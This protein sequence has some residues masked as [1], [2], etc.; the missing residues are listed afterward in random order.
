MN[1]SVVYPPGAARPLGLLTSHNNDIE[2]F[3][4]D[5]AIP[6]L[7]V[8]LL[9]KYLPRNIR[10]NNVHVL[11]SKSNVVQACKI[12]QEIDGRRKLYI[13]DG[14]MELLTGSPKPRLRHLY[15]L[16]GYCVENYLLDEGALV[17]AVT[18]VNTRIDEGSARQQINFFGWLERNQ[19]CLKGLF[20]CYAVSYEMKRDVQ[21]V[22]FS[23]YRLLKGGNNYDLSE[24]K[25][26]RRI[27]NLYRRIRIDFSKDHTR[28]VYERVRM[29]AETIGLMQF[30]S[31]KD[32][33]FPPIYQVIKSRNRTNITMDAFKVLV[34]QCL[35]SAKDSYLLRRIRKI[36]A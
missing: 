12:D 19:K 10:L 20:V 21:T 17:S 7:W 13:I 29:N 6:N 8:K 1:T 31:G 9:R 15:R 3:V 5:T 11:G 34:A 25:V 27:M 14:D 36:C 35:E 28:H 2:I 30:A 23:V 32:Y 4:E 18:T 26:N 24:N 22:G 33:I 16:R